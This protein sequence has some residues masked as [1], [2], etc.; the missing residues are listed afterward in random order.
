MEYE[1]NSCRRITMAMLLLSMSTTGFK[2]PSSISHETSSIPIT[3]VSITRGARTV[4]EAWIND[5]GSFPLQIYY[6]SFHCSWIFKNPL[7]YHQQMQ[8]IL[9]VDV[10]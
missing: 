8:L 4:V 1:S 2:E 5:R 3:E 10:S 9:C 7:T 6:W